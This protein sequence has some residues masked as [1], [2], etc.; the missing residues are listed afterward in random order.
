MMNRVLPLLKEPVFETRAFILCESGKEP[1]TISCSLIVLVPGCLYLV[2]KETD[3]LRTGQVLSRN[4]ELTRAS[5][6]DPTVS[7]QQVFVQF[8]SLFDASRAFGRI[9]PRYQTK[10]LPELADWWLDAD[11]LMRQSW[12][13]DHAEPEEE[14]KFVARATERVSKHLRDTNLEK[15][16]ARGRTSKA[17]SLEDKRGRRNVGR[18][19]LLCGS[20]E[21]SLQKRRLAVRGIGPRMDWRAVVIQYYLDQLRSECFLIRREAQST[22]LNKKIF[23]PGERS[24]GEMRKLAQRMTAYAQTLSTFCARPFIRRFTHVACELNEASRLLIESANTRD[25]TSADL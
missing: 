23:V 4:L 7:E 19:P 22:L 20:V 13:I 14:A 9:N 3:G 15:V 2:Q 5:G 17:G 10:E 24:A 21:R 11:W 18:I 6:F 1:R 25:G 16:S 12:T 8:H